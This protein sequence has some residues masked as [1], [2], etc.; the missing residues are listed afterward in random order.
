MTDTITLTVTI[1]SYD[2]RGYNYVTVKCP[3]ICAT[4]DLYE[5]QGTGKQ[6]LEALG[7]TSFSEAM[8]GRQV[9]ITY[10]EKDGP[11]MIHRNGERV[12]NWSF[13]P[14]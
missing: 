13:S 8:V 10:P 6:L 7:M 1:S 4:F 14:I 3:E 11:R 2:P 5:H 9:R 12:A